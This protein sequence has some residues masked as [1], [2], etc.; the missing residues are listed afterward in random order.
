MI[1]FLDLGLQYRGIKVEIDLAI[2]TIIQNTDFIN[3]QS[4]REFEQEFSAYIDV[5]HCIGVGNGTDA[6]EIAIES[7]GLPKGA[8]IIVPG[9]S[10]IA[11]SEAVTRAGHRVQFCDCRE[12]TFSM[13][14]EDVERR[15]TESTKALVVVHMYGNPCDM[16]AVTKLAEKYNLRIVEDCAQAHGAKYKG[17]MVGGFGDVGAFSFY[18]GKNL[19]AYGDAGAIVTSDHSLSEKIRM[20]GNHGRI[21]KYDHEFEGRNSRLDGLQAAI[22]SVKL[23]HLDD[24][25]ARRRAVAEAY[26]KNI[27]QKD[28]VR[29][30]TL[31]NSSEC[32]Y[33]L[34][35]VRV[36][37]RDELKNYLNTHGV[38]TGIHYPVALPKL[39]AY[40]YLQQSSGDM[41]CN[42]LDGKVLSLP[43]GEHITMK[44]VKYISDLINEFYK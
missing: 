11:S 24:W 32:A 39:N 15:I 5:E 23:K 34:F 12:D 35:V 30:M 19:G 43:M 41:V 37:R 2:E 33:H 38:E 26:L 28:E 29:C 44:N 8:E 21:S 3:G 7:F 6:L 27:V 22:L 25:V 31:L 20:I 36:N 16:D 17:K 13:D 1:K 18:P 4:V 40:K 10:F 9:N 14:I 42:Q